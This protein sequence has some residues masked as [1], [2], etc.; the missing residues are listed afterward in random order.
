MMGDL[1]P[2]PAVSVQQRCRP[3][4]GAGQHLHPLRRCA[5]AAECFSRYAQETCE[6]VFTDALHR[7]SISEVRVFIK[8]RAGSPQSKGFCGKFTVNCDLCLV[9]SLAELAE[10]LSQGPCPPPRAII[11]N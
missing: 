4:V 2:I 8:G 11:E 5:V 7:E 1:S 10:A 6:L 3:G 9:L